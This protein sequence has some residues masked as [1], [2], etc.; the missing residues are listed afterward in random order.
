[1]LTARLRV[2]AALRHDVARPSGI[3][4]VPVF[5]LSK[6]GIG[7]R[8]TTVTTA[9]KRYIADRR[10]NYPPPLIITGYS[11]RRQPQTQTQRSL[12]PLSPLRAT[13][14]GPHHHRPT[15]ISPLARHL[16]SR[17]ND[18]FTPCHTLGYPGSR[19]QT[20]GHPT[21][22]F[23]TD[24]PGLPIVP[25]RMVEQRVV[26]RSSICRRAAAQAYGSV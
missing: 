19:R 21:T 16:P 22:S 4:S 10:A 17:Q 7:P 8:M 23:K 20:S 5:S 3:L 15:P 13:C 12:T 1:M 14:P 6:L 25:R 11:Q 2:A 18:Y 26:Q 9:L 24:T